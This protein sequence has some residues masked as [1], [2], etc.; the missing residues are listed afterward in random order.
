MKEKFLDLLHMGTMEGIINW[1]EG[2]ISTKSSYYF[3]TKIDDDTEVSCSISMK[4]DGSIKTDYIT[5]R[6][7][8]LLTGKVHFHG[9]EKKVIEIGNMIYH[10]YIQPNLIILKKDDDILSEIIKN[11]PTK[12]IDRDKKIKTIIDN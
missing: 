9:G 6:N 10:K 5:L 11:M 2:S 3:N 4:S 12:Q 1:K 8:K 7:E